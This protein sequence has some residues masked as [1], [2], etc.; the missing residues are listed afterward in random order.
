MKGFTSDIDKA[1]AL[2]NESINA[3]KEAP[4]QDIKIEQDLELKQY[5]GKG[6]AYAV[7]G[8]IEI[9]ILNQS[10][11]VNL[12]EIKQLLENVE[13]LKLPD[14]RVLTE[15]REGLHWLTQ[16][17]RIRL[18]KKA[19]EVC[20]SKLGAA[21]MLGLDRVTLYRTLKSEEDLNAGRAPGGM[22]YTRGDMPRKNKE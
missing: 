13:T 18:I 9:N 21:R 12:F 8:N 3:I 11:L 20:G 5:I 10:V 4:K 15:P 19:I 2:I 6:K 14:G 22:K 7:Q 17:Y 16:R 1:L